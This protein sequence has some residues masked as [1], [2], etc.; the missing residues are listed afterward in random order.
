MYLNAQRLYRNYKVRSA[1]PVYITDNHIK[2]GYNI[3]Q[4][5]T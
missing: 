2:L 1:S 3:C 4:I 5:F